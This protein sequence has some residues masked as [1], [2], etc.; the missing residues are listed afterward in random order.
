MFLLVL[1]ATLASC[2]WIRNKPKA[3]SGF[4]NQ[5]LDLSCLQTAP[6]QLTAVF[7]GTVTASPE[8]TEK[9]KA[10]FSCLDHALTVFSDYTRGEN[11]DSYTS[12]ELKNFANQH[13]PANAPLT[14]SFINSIFLM[15]RAVIGGT[16]KS[17]TK[18]EVKILR[19]KLVKFGD[20]I[21]PLA[22]HMRTLVKPSEASPE[23]R[24]AAGAALDVF[25]QALS[26][27][28]GNSAHPLEWADFKAFISDLELYT[29]TKGN[30]NALTFVREQIPVF[31]YA[32]LLFVGG[33]DTA[34]ETEKWRPI[35]GS[36]SHFYSAFMNTRTASEL[37]E[38][39]SIEVLSTEEEQ[40]RAVKKL[41]ELL[42]TMM[43]DGQLQSRPLV[44]SLT[45]R[46][47][48]ALFIN[49]IIF[50]RSQGSLALKPFLESAPVRKLAGR[51]VDQAM[52]I[53]LNHL[54]AS[55]LQPIVKDLVS[56][57]EQAG[58]ADSRMSNVKAVLNLS[59]AIQYLDEL[60]PLLEDK[61]FAD[62]IKKYVDLSKFAI[63]ILVGNDGDSLR[64]REVSAI[65]G[66]AFDL[67]ATWNPDSTGS[68]NA[69]IGDT[70]EILTRTPSFSSLTTVQIED[71]LNRAQKILQDLSPGTKLDWELIRSWL[72]RGM[73]LKAL[74]FRT[75][76]TGISINELAQLAALY[77][78]LR[79]G[80]DLVR[81]L[82]S[83]SNILRESD[84]PNAPIPEVIDA[85][86][87]FL[88][89]ES[90]TGAL[91]I[92]PELIRLV[93]PVL[94]GGDLNTFSRYDYSNL[95]RLAANGMQTLYPKYKALG[96]NF[97]PGLD[98]T[99]FDL[100]NCALHAFIDSRR[101]EISLADLKLLVME[102][103][104]RINLYPRGITVD[105]FL[106][107][108]HTRVLKH[109][110]SQKPDSLKGL[111]FLATDLGFFENL[112]ANIR[113]ELLPLE[114]TFYNPEGT[115]TRDE[116]LGRLRSEG[117]KKMGRYKG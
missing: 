94:L 79:N 24:L 36:I 56:L 83:L 86:N 60:K 108:L 112:T 77:E 11:P 111:V 78:P 74:V 40:T 65:V 106:I 84:I 104:K 98:S 10:I 97:K 46:Y 92:T 82:F 64:P 9:T 54:S 61:T 90:Q 30:T 71:T 7:S 45:D 4:Q 1:I 103:L 69:K 53:D 33:S 35:F 38:Q 114:Q 67:F 99:T 76:E 41:S 15:K 16:V 91:G 73:K 68:M 19:S 51:I 89:P 110:K 49:A 57:I 70:L 85:V 14:D 72:K 8:D 81:S 44:I 48:K 58:V 87:S 12:E 21:T 26:E 75:P 107:G 17:L 88:P 2:G 59:K 102:G 22:P 80:Q 55:A 23:L 25:V 6:K 101:G 66:K 43:A 109:S 116:L 93:K 37:L 18:E 52:K 47:A 29:R 115:L 3:Q 13:L 39:M 62:T 32:K 34:I 96:P 105:R 95:A 20:A 5:A 113:D 42:R 100:A 31:Q 27:I 63:P 50:P 117:A 28:L